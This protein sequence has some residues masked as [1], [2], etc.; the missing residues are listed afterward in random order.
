MSAYYIRCGADEA[1]ESKLF[2][3]NCVVLKANPSTRSRVTKPAG[4]Y[5]IRLDACQA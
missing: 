1:V 4:L 3:H 2:L 5:L